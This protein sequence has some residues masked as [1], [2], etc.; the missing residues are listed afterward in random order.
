MAGADRRRLRRAIRIGFIVAVVT[1]GAVAVWKQWPEVK[2]SVDRLSLVTLVLALVAVTAGL[3]AAMCVWRAILA[4]LGS[5]LRFS[6]AARI[7]FV[8][9]LGK[10]IP[11]SVW[12]ILAHMEMARDQGVPRR[13]SGVSYAITILVNFVVGLALAA[14]TLPFVAADAA[15]HYMWLFLLAPLIAAGLHPRILNPGLALVFRLIRRD[16]PERPLT[17][18]GLRT[19]G[20]Y[21][22]ACW[23]FFGLHVTLI[24]ADLGVGFGQAFALSVGGFALAWIAGFLLVVAPAGAGAREVALVAVLAPVLDRGAAIVVALVSRLVMTVGDL[25]AAAGTV[26]MQA[27]RRRSQSAGSRAGR[28]QAGA[29]TAPGRV[30]GVGLPFVKSGGDN[31]Q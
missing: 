29:A 21:A 4:D 14:A 30:D 9:Q 7:F 10:Y 24:A 18:R 5:P 6:T 25:I 11:G 26:L 1:L 13:R 28:R 31:P 23:L 2:D 8:G 12:P 19:A 17:W 27:W 20:A 22:L 3:T 16:P 15:G